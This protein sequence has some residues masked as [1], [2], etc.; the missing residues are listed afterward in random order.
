MKRYVAQ[1]K[2]DLNVAKNA[3]DEL[4]EHYEILDTLTPAQDEE[5]FLVSAKEESLAEIIGFDK[6]LFPPAN[7]LTKNQTE[8]LFKHL[9]E[10]I[11]AHSFYLDLPQML[12]TCIKYTL[13]LSILNDQFEIYIDGLTVIDFCDYDLNTCPFG[14][15][16]CLCKEY[17]E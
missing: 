12:D 16:H 10:L 1:L 11:E 9:N 13:V 8:V 15:E 4:K 17:N 14:T 3:V 7:R 2:G 5:E 6:I